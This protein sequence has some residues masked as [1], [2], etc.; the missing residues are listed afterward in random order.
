MPSHNTGGG[1]YTSSFLYNSNNDDRQACCDE[2]C[3]SGSGPQTRLRTKN[4]AETSLSMFGKAQSNEDRFKNYNLFNNPFG[5]YLL[6]FT[7]ICSG[8]CTGAPSISPPDVSSSTPS[9][10]NTSPKM[11]NNLLHLLPFN[12]EATC[13]NALTAADRQLLFDSKTQHSSV[14]QNAGQLG[15]QHQ[16]KH[17]SKDSSAWVNNKLKKANIL[18]PG[19]EKY[20]ESRMPLAQKICGVKMYTNRKIHKSMIL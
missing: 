15:I 13:V 18:R 16:F 12:N 10:S 3:S 2:S 19:L 11:N 8:I 20:Y 7:P 17:F 6:I 9:S 4:T 1:C 14:L 5:H